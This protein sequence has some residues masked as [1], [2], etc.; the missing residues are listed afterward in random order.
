MQIAKEAFKLMKVGCVPPKSSA[1]Y[2]FVA[3]TRASQAR[4]T[5]HPI[6]GIKCA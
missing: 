2:G 3:A 6:L 5:T 4:Y 1:T